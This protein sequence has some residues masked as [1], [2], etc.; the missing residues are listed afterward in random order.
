MLGSH[1]RQLPT[2]KATKFS[3]NGVRRFNAVLELRIIALYYLILLKSNS[4]LNTVFPRAVAV[5]AISQ[6]NKFRLISYV[7]LAAI[8]VFP[9]F[10]H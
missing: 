9:G 5:L 3:K 2:H 8:V 1:F 4:E 7:K 10:K 6:R